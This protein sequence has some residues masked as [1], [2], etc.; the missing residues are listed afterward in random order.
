[1]YYVVPGNAQQQQRPIQQR[2]KNRSY[3]LDRLELIKRAGQS[4]I[5]RDKTYL[6]RPFVGEMIQ[7]AGRLE[8]LAT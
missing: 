6:D 2:R 7:E 3:I 4:R 1:M 5:M 8:R